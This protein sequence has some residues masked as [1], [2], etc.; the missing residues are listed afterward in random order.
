MTRRLVVSIPTSMCMSPPL[1]ATLEVCS[2]SSRY[3]EEHWAAVADAHR[4]VASEGS[5]APTVTVAD[6]WDINRY[7]AA[8]WHTAAALLI[9][10]GGHPQAIKRQMGHSSIRVTMDTYGHL[11][12]SEA[13]GWRYQ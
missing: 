1:S 12:P 11:Y 6:L 3:P 10:Q 7:T 13:E 9:S 2:V 4:E 8:A 5:R